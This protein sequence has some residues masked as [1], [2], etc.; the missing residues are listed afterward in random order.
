MEKCNGN[1]Q[2]LTE[3]VVVFIDSGSCLCITNL[4]EVVTSSPFVR[5]QCNSWAGLVTP[6]ARALGFLMLEHR[7]TLWKL[8]SEL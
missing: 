5:G 1:E 4:F 8:F 3:C 6:D 7:M 2:Q